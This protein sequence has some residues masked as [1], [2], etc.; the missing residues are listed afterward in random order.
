MKRLWKILNNKSA[1]LVFTVPKWTR[2][3]NTYKSNNQGFRGRQTNLYRNIGV[4][5]RGFS[6]APPPRP[7]PF[8]PRRGVVTARCYPITTVHTL[9]HTMP[10]RKL[11]PPVL[12][13][14]ECCNR[15]LLVLLA[16]VFTRGIT[17]AAASHHPPA[18]A[19]DF[20]LIG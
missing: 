4:E 7:P 12:H 20:S 9:H 13:L 8:P 10:P 6:E 11:I 2:K 1:L 19:S 18:T 16:A 14:H 3:S 5:Q 17:T 15:G